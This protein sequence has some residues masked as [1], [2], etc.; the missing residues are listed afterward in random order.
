M[1]DDDSPPHSC[2]ARRLSPSHLRRDLP[3]GRRYLP[4]LGV[5]CGSCCAGIITPAPIEPAMLDRRKAAQ[6][7]CTQSPCNEAMLDWIEKPLVTAGVERAAMK[8][9]GY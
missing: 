3:G 7:T 6:A 9:C 8:S 1:T 5:V 2:G 4:G